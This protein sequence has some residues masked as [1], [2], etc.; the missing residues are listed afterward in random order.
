MGTSCGTAKP[1]NTSAGTS[2]SAASVFGAAVAIVPSNFPPSNKSSSSIDSG[3]AGS[4]S[5]VVNTFETRFSSVV[6]P[7]PFGPRRTLNRSLNLRSHGSTS[8]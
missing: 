5:F 3:S 2:G 6:F 4:S 1:G 7:A 8:R